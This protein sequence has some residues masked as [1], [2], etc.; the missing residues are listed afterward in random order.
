M[1]LGAKMKLIRKMIKK[2]IIRSRYWFYFFMIGTLLFL[3]LRNYYVML[4]C[5]IFAMASVMLIKIDYVRLQRYEI[6]K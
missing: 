2:R 5:V 6:K 4:L 1:I 3:I